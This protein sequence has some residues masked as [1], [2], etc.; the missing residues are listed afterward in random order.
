MVLTPLS[1][2]EVWNQL[3]AGKDVRAIVIKGVNFKDNTVVP[4][5]DLTVYQ[6]SEAISKETDAIFCVVKI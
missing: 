1:R 6:I 2:L 5:R 3:I 4:L